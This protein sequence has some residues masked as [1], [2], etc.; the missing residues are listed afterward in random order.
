MD[1]GVAVGSGVGV[2]VGKGVAVG[3]IEHIPE[4][5]TTFDPYV[6]VICL[7]LPPYAI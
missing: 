6:I 1:V 7:V 2:S 3:Q 4:I 5:G